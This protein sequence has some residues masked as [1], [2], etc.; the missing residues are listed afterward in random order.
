MGLISLHQALKAAVATSSSNSHRLHSYQGGTSCSGKR[1]GPEVFLWFGPRRY[2]V[3]GA[4]LEATMECGW[5]SLVTRLSST[6][7]TYAIKFVG[8]NKIKYEVS[9]R[10]CGWFFFRRWNYER[11]RILRR[12]SK[13]PVFLVKHPTISL[14]LLKLSPLPLGTSAKKNGKMW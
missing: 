13:Y 3:H 14:A 8:W 5:L 6:R 9:C 12:I 1:K 2:F 4:G 7:I 11:S 10:K